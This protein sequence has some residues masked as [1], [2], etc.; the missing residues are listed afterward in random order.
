M[1][2]ANFLPFTSKIVEHSRYLPLI[3]KHE[4]KVQK[5]KN[6]PASALLAG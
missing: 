6:Y 4:A 2:R 3:E 1:F 5:R